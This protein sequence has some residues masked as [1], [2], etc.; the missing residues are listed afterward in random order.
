VT[1]TASA[2]ADALAYWTAKLGGD[3]AV[4]DLLSAH[5]PHRLQPAEPGPAVH[6]APV[7]AGPEVVAAQHRLAR[8]ERTEPFVVALAGFTVFLA[9]MTGQRDVVV[10]AARPD[11]VALRT[12]L[13]GDPTFREVVRRVRET[14]READEHAG[15]PLAQ[16]LD[17]VGGPRMPGV[18]SLFQVTFRHGPTDHPTDHDPADLG[19]AD[20]SLALRETAGG[21]LAGSVEC[22]ADL[23]DQPAVTRFATIVAHLLESTAAT[24]DVPVFG[25]PALPRGE[26][27]RMLH[28]LHRHARPEIGQSTMA[29]PFE[30]QARRTPDAQALVTE[31]GESLTYAEL[32]ER[33]NRLAWHLRG[34]GARAGTFVAVSM[35]R[36]LDLVVA[37]YAVAK[38][39]AAYVPVEP[40]L[41]AARAEFMLT[42]AGPVAVLVDG[43]SRDGVPDGQWTVLAVDADAARWAGE[44]A[45]DV[46]AEPVPHLIHL[47]YTSGTTGRPK[48]VAYPVDGALADIGWL[49]EAYPYGPGDTAILKTSYG[50]DVSIWEIW[51]PLYRGSRVLICPPGAHRDPDRLRDLVDRFGVTAMF[52][53]P[54]MMGPFHERTGP[55]SCPSLRWLLCGGEAVPPRIRDGFHERFA[56]QIVN[57][58]GPT[59]LG[60]VAETVL[61]V[62][63]GAPVMVGRP[64]AHRRVYVLDDTLAPTPVGVPGELFVGGEVGMADGYHR[65]P[66][67]TAERFLPDPFGP[68]GERMYRTGDLVRF[69]EDGELEHL[70]RIGRQVKIRGMRIELAEIEA[71]LSE[72]ADVAS[73]VVTVPPGG[74]GEIAAFVAPQPGGRVAVPALLAHAARQLPAHM[75]P[76]TVTAVDAIPT[77]VNGKTDV[78]AL[79]RLPRT[80]VTG[81]EPHVGPVGTT[82]VAVAALFA[83]LLERESVSVV[84]SFLTLG[85]HSLLVLRLLDRVADEHGVELGIREVL[86][87]LTVR[88]LAALITRRAAEEGVPP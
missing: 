19:R 86:G 13:A 20:L 41:P 8:D 73:C 3:L 62:E 7:H 53:V 17:A 25:L 65:R 34:L 2:P 51:W 68:P 46:P 77:F 29:Q 39:G 85:G 21:E 61:P 27:E 15:V 69:R 37:L 72:Q 79:L 66:A 1:T 47:L 16:V 9:R 56:G 35:Q 11:P 40:E 10:G 60:C 57:C 49:H 44:P 12:G 54:S 88:D 22:P 59:E 84:E 80:A 43:C 28:G 70:G 78:Q 4:L 23:V 38:S 24:P 76:A 52:M 33:A 64:P 83:E 14:V 31:D 81:T 30:E 48:A 32:N 63:P 55:G 67:L 74:D 45:D 18:P 87:A 50:F 36:S 5:R 82:E 58:Y 42:D 71:V 6:R 75:L 26:R